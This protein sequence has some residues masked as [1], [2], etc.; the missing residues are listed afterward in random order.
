MVKVFDVVQYDRV[1]EQMKVML[2]CTTYILN[3]SLMVLIDRG[4]RY[5]VSATVN[6]TKVLLFSQVQVD[7]A[8]SSMAHLSVVGSMS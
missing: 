6:M 8:C 2:L 1:V 3:M 7:N 4:V 5:R